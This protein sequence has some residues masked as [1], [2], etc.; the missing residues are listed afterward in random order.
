MAFNY[1]PKIVT[2]GLILY[3]DAANTKSY[4]SGSTVWNDISRTGLNPSLFNGPIFD[5]NN[6]GSITLDGS[7]DNI[8]INSFP[9]QSV[10]HI[11]I[12]TKPTT[13][14]NGAASPRCLILL[15]KNNIGQNFDDSNWYIAFGAITNQLVNEY[16][17]I[18]TLAT[19]I[20]N[21]RTAVTDGGSLLANTWYN[22]CINWNGTFYDIYVNGV[23]RNVVSSTAG[24]VPRLTNPNCLALGFRTGDAVA[25]NIFYNGSYST[26]SIYNKSLTDQQILQNYNATKTR[27]GL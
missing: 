8:I 12:F 17:T 11:S 1:S 20:V 3:L 2:D 26:V 10:D 7:N 19:G 16:I 15:R 6:A 21:R 14:I 9:S 5:S 23:K 25:D 13:T 27:F 24:H 4:V 22:I 18:A